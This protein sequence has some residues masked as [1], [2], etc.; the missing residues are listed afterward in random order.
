[1]T[2]RIW[3]VS[4]RKVGGISFLKLGRINISFSVSHPKPEPV[5]PIYTVRPSIE[6]AEGKFHPTLTLYR[7]GA[8]V[9]QRHGEAFYSAP[10]AMAFARSA[11]SRCG[12]S[13]A[14]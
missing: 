9:A 2:N 3:N 8:P 1:M 13:L 12:F 14:R 5:A 4:H 10:H 11:A 7:D 6:R